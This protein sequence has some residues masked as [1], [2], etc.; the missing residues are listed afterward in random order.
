[1][2]NLVYEFM[3][4]S[5]LSPPECALLPVKTMLKI[6]QKIPTIAD[7]L[8]QIHF[9]SSKTMCWADRDQLLRA[10]DSLIC[11]VGR[12]WDPPGKAE[13]TIA[14]PGK[15]F[16]VWENDDVQIPHDQVGIVIRFP[17]KVLNEPDVDDLFRP[18][19]HS[20]EKH[21]GLALCTAHRIIESHRGEIRVLN[22]AGYGLALVVL[23]PLAGSDDWKAAFPLKASA[24]LHASEG[25]RA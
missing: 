12:Q 9:T 3:E 5:R 6:L 15:A 20:D 18:F 11:D 10:L 7:Y 22:A 1:L 25:V 13:L 2:N 17:G 16:E 19:R 8:E 24:V 21:R 14:E 4:F 23:I